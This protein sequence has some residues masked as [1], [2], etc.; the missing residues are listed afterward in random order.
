MKVRVEVVAQI[1]PEKSGKRPIIKNEHLRDFSL[2][3]R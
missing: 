3:S 1:P 2:L